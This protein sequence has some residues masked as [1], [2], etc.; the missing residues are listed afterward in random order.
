[1]ER[2]LKD[3]FLTCLSK[4][5]LSAG[6][7]LIE[8]GLVVMVMGIIATISLPALNSTLQGNRLRGAA[9]EVVTA[10][11]YAQMTAITSGREIQVCIGNSNERIKLMQ[12]LSNAD[13]FTG[14]DELAE[15]DV[16]NGTYQVMPYPQKKGLNYDFDFP[17]IDRFK[18]VDITI[19][20]F[21]C[22]QNLIFDVQGAPSKGG[23]VTLVL[24]GEQIVVTLD[25]LT[26]KVSVSD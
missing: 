12:Y 10:L 11:E 20:D 7:T 25:A 21:N 15:N 22:T 26:G 13:F 16:E 18:G 17:D 9:D 4:L 24:G 1:M 5:Q 3:I 19:S 8:V 23:S 14:G 6:F 2:K